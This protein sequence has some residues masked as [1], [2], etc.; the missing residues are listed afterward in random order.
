M[1]ALLGMSLFA[2]Q[3]TSYAYWRQEE[4][5]PGVAVWVD[6]NT[7]DGAKEDAEAAAQDTGAA[8]TQVVS[9]EAEAGNV[10]ADAAGQGMSEAAGQ[11]YAGQN[12]GTEGGQNTAGQSASTAGEANPAAG[13]D[14]NA[15]GGAN[16]AE[17]ATA[18]EAQDPNL[19]MS[20][21][22]QLDLRKPMIA[23]TYDDGPN[24]KV[25]DRIM[26][27]L[28]QYQ[29]RATFFMVGERVRSFPAEVQRMAVEGH[30]L[31]NHSYSHPYFNKLDAPSI[32]AQVE[33]T[34]QVIEAVSGV[35]PGLMRLPGGNKN[36]TVLANVNMP[37][38]L[39]SID[40]RDWQTRNAQKTAD[41]VLGKV[42]DGDIVLMHELYSST[43]DATEAIV[44]K[45]AAQ[46][47][48]FVTVSELAKWKGKTLL[49]NQ[50]Y[51]DIR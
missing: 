29:G 45:L 17:T 39:W 2:A 16:A 33:Q 11:E 48:Q 50:V 22:R 42:K 26:N 28:A 32:R 41:A 5:G 43:A 13:Q 35:R 12:A 9:P 24:A 1:A 7:A 19:V 47:F 4:L 49:P 14:S 36:S 20:N 21:G 8:D 44:P 51:Y 18:S 23:L 15:A 31:G 40:T 10:S 46:G 3:M 25:G 34:N 6:E 38:V 30:E 37:I 27:V